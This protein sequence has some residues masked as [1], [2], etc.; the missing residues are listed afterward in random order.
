MLLGECVPL[1]DPLAPQWRHS[2]HDM[3]DTAFMRWPSVL[4]PVNG[5]DG[6]NLTDCRRAVSLVLGVSLP[7]K[8]DLKRGQAILIPIARF[9]HP[10]YQKPTSYLVGWL[11]ALGW[12]TAMPTV[13]YATSLQ[14]LALIATCEPDYVAEGWHGALLTIAFV[15]LAI[16]INLFA[17]NKMPLIQGLVVMAHISGFVSSRI[18]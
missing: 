5:R 2:R 16:S 12:Q 18:V 1:I 6:I 17:I 11:C 7:F 15:L 8:Q 9:S 14:V 4:D 10:Q 13:A 3:D